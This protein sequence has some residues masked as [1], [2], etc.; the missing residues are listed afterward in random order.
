MLK[1]NIYPQ[2]SAGIPEG[3]AGQGYTKV[4]AT[5]RFPALAASELILLNRNTR[6]MLQPKVR[7][8]PRNCANKT[9]RKK[10]IDTHDNPTSSFL[11]PPHSHV[12]LAKLNIITATLRRRN[13]DLER[14]SRKR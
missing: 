10:Q 11:F 3:Q 7:I 5:K 2:R 4:G 8:P 6:M 13:L 1:Q 9:E 14:G 12:G